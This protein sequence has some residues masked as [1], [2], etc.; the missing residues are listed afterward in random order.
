MVKSRGF[1]LLSKVTA[2]II[3][4]Y[5]SISVALLMSL[6]SVVQTGR[7]SG[8]ST[9]TR[10]TGAQSKSWLTDPAQ[11][12]RRDHSPAALLGDVLAFCSLTIAN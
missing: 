7:V 8:T 4:S 12:M 1:L 10:G 3:S 6:L 9:K 5:F 2:M 11:N